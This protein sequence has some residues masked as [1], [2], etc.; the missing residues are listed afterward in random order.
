MLEARERFT[1]DQLNA[2]EVVKNFSE[3]VSSQKV[4]AIINRHKRI[5]HEL[6]AS[7]SILPVLGSG[8]HRHENFGE[9][10]NKQR[11]FF[12]DEDLGFLLLGQPSPEHD[13]RIGLAE[14]SF[15]LHPLRGYPGIVD[16]DTR[17]YPRIVQM[18][19]CTYEGD[20]NWRRE[21]AVKLLKSFQMGKVLLDLVIEFARIHDFPAVG[22]LPAASN[23]NKG[24]KGFN[25]E[26]MK[27]RYDIT[28]ERHKFFRRPGGL[29]V[30]EIAGSHIIKR[31]K[32]NMTN[33]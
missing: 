31:Q 29:L 19:G 23:L 33:L 30:K 10:R 32:P 28:A 5:P 20:R 3:S 15:S 7:F 24:K 21:A 17:Q 9:P 16:N 8:R 26:K 12:I 2:C 6:G 1:Q 22:V 18:Q 11:K 25:L 13:K 27:I 14:V 4:N